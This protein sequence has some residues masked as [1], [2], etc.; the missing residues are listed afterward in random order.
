MSPILSY[1]KANIGRRTN[2]YKLISLT[3]TFSTGIMLSRRF[4][5]TY[6]IAV[7]ILVAVL[8]GVAYSFYLSR[9]QQ[10]SV[11][12]VLTS[13]TTTTETRQGMKL[14]IG[15]I[16]VVD[17]FMFLVADEEGLFKREGLDIEIYMFGSARD[18]DSALVSGSIDVAINDP[19]GALMLI[20]RNISIKIIGF[21]CCDSDNES[22]VGF[23]LL[24]SP[25]STEPLEYV[26]SIA[27]SRN[28][29]IEYVAWKMLRGLG[30]DPSR[31]NFID[32][33]S[34]TTRYELLI[35]GKIPAAVLPDPW[36]SLAVKN[37]AKIVAKYRDLVVLV[38]RENILKDPVGREELVK[39]AR[40]LN[41]A[42][43]LYNSNPEKYRKI[44]E[45]KLFIPDQLKGLFTIEW[46]SK[47]RSVPQ[48]LIDEVSRWL[49][50]RGLIN[51]VY[52]YS[53][54]VDN[55]V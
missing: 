41:E 43:E 55:V 50:E 46:K 10:S 45:E 13:T 27:I 17:S 4:Y 7:L 53:V 39:L 9:I 12:A 19:V 36:G 26:N 16:P 20:S 42:I 29:I 18:R 15:L 49:Y 33:P 22:N 47:I 31:I 14:R 38:A 34:I 2:I 30:M 54:Y 32:T 21:L 24:L 8:V 35:E 28:T 44:I 6:I 51:N 48:D 25:N 23:Y 1:K 5:I 3:S 37:G 52:N 40:V 11:A